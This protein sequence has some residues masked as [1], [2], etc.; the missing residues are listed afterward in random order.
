MQTSPGEQRQRHSRRAPRRLT[1]GPRPGSGSVPGS[2]PG[3]ATV[4]SPRRTPCRR[5]RA[6][7]RR[8]MLA[9]RTRRSAEGAAEGQVRG[10]DQAGE[11]G[12]PG[13]VRP[14]HREGQGPRRTR[15]DSARPPKTPLGEARQGH[16]A[17]P[18]RLRGCEGH[19]GFDGAS[20][21][22]AWRRGSSSEEGAVVAAADAGRLGGT[23]AMAV[24][25]KVSSP[26]RRS[27]RRSAPRPRRA[28]SS[29]CEGGTSA[30]NAAATALGK[31][32]AKAADITTIDSAT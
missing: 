20:I 4:K 2:R 19:G 28:S 5:P 12:H 30:V 3:P 27:P 9:G 14:G 8:Q 26:R 32:V 18:V 10:G 15:R 31:N 13:H 25:L 1:T 29:A 11:A 22:A 6:A 23:A 7:V 17:G 24:A 16:R 21:A